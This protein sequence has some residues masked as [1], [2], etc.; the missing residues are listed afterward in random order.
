M[1]PAFGCAPDIP[2]SPAVTKSIPFMFSPVPASPLAF[3]CLRAAFITVI[4]VPC[5]MPCGPMY[6]YEPAV[7]WP[8]CDTPRALNLSQS[9]GLE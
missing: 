3:N 8:Y 2:P 4:V 6:M 5:T 9:S 1:F 7:I